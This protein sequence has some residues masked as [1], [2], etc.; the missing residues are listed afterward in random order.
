MIR[1]CK[2]KD[3]LD[4]ILSVDSD[5]PVFLFKHSNICP[6][7]TAARDEFVLF[8]NEEERASFWQVLVRENRDLSLEFADRLNVTHQSPQVILLIK[9]RAVSDRSHQA[10]K[11]PQLR[12][13][14]AE[15]AV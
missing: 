2:T 9:G 11:L 8:A 3:N 6:V 13:M 15:F 14:I 4:E 7:S 12:D 5:Q 10:I 1:E